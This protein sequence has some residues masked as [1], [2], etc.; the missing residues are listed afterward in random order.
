MPAMIG[1][2][3]NFLLPLI[4]GGPDMVYPRLNNIS[5][6][7]LPPSLILFLFASG[8]E[9]GAGTGWTLYPPLSGIQSH[10]GPSVDLAIFSLHLAGIS[11]LLGAMNFITTILNMRSPGIR[12]HKLALFGWAVLTT[13][14]LL[15]LSLPVLA[16]AITMI[17]TD[18][19]FNTSFFETAGGG[20]PILYQ[21]LF[22]RGMFINKK[23]YL[24]GVFLLIIVTIFSINSA[25]SNKLGSKVKFSSLNNNFD[26]SLFYIKHKTYLA[27]KSYPSNKFLTWFIGF[28]EGEG[29]FIVNN[30]GDLAFVITQSTSDIKVLQFIQE[31]LGFGKV[32]AQSVNTSRY[33]T[34]SKREIDILISILNGNIVLPSRQEKFNNFIKGFNSWVTKGK[35]KLDT[36]VTKNMFILPSLD[37]S[38][39]AGFTDAEGCFTCSISEKK[40][41]SINFNIAQKGEINVKILEHI[42][43]LFKCGI[44]SKHAV[45]NVYEYRIGGVKNC[46]NVF[47]YF[48]NFTLYTK[49]SMSYILWKQVYNDL[50]DK[51]HLDKSKRLEM[52][53]KARMINKY[54]IV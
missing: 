27:N 18:R 15:L 2:F 12:L 17:L 31:T 52:I 24:F 25:H 43:L 3:G 10:S 53:E 21:H 28:T 41:Y 40:G 37:N 7:L 29:S 46:K 36:V 30:R 48:D 13:A 50:G 6:W 4:V 42:C 32:I 49:K 16:G 14:V 26:F 1:G 38:W 5:F 9:N 8:I 44:V 33:V 47:P 51:C 34:Q 45:E 39:L 22:S 23:C 54:N 11:S 19:N 35:I 20:D